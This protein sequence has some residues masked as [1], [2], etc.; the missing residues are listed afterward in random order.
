MRKG[1]ARMA[2]AGVAIAAAVATIIRYNRQKER[3]L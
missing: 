2:A 1:I 3:V